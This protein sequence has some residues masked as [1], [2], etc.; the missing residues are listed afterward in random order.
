MPCCFQPLSALTLTL[1]CACHSCLHPLSAL[2][3]TR[4]VSWR[5]VFIFGNDCRGSRTR[6]KTAV[7]NIVFDDGTPQERLT[8]GEIGV[9]VTW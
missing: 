7:D 5:A 6:E 4:G 1:E 2:L 8:T 9:Y 3:P